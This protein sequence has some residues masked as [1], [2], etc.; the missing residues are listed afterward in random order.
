MLADAARRYLGVKWRHRGRSPHAVDCAGV[1]IL[2][3]RDCG[4]ELPDYVLYGREPHHDGLI[5]YLTAALGN[6]MPAGTEPLDGDVIVFRFVREPHHVAIVGDAYY[7]D[8][9]A[10]NIIHSDGQVGR[11]IEQRL[12]P[13]MIQRITHVYRKGVE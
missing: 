3:Y 7:G 8:T 9:K 11:V 6:P 12:T 2:A 1:G 13:D 5:K 4:I 10:L